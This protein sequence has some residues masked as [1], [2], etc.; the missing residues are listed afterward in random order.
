[1]SL[2]LG[3]I[4]L[5]DCLK[6]FVWNCLW[7][8]Y[9][10]YRRKVHK[11][12]VQACASSLKYVNA[13]VL[14]SE[15]KSEAHLMSTFWT[16]NTCHSC[17]GRV[18]VWGSVFCYGKTHTQCGRTFCP[19]YSISWF[20]FFSRS[21]ERRVTFSSQLT[22]NHLAAAVP[23]SQVHHQSWVLHCAACQLRECWGNRDR[24]DL[25]SE[26]PKQAYVVVY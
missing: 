13:H 6:R 21:E 26:N 2:K 22:K 16:R 20:I 8:M 19:T 24:V 3:C 7:A 15:K 12:H 4:V 17:P 5:W 9:P 23:S 14:E 1:M 18:T 11:F 10:K 25:L